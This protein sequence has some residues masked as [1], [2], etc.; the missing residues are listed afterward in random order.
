MSAFLVA[1]QSHLVC[2]LQCDMFVD[3]I[4]LQKDPQP[5]FSSDTEAGSDG[6]SKASQ[7][8]QP[9]S[10]AEDSVMQVRHCL[11]CQHPFLCSLTSSQRQPEWQQNL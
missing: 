4:C 1:S 8:L 7:A 2:L 6:M 9:M 5:A 3:G 10:E 11:P